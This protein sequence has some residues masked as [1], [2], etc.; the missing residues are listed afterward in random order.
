M[1][2]DGLDIGDGHVLTVSK[3]D[4]SHRQQQSK[5]DYFLPHACQSDE[6]PVVVLKNVYDPK[7]VRNDINFLVNLE[8]DLVDECS[9][10]GVVKKVLCL[11]ILKI[12]I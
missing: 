11:G 12:E 4:F 2:C 9:K 1:Q 7:I 10:S 6:F 8:A 5:R 3:A